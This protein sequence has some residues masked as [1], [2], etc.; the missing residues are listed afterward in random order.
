MREGLVVK[1]EKEELSPEGGTKKMHTGNIRRS[2]ALLQGGVH[3]FRLPNNINNVISLWEE[4]RPGRKIFVGS[5]Q[6]H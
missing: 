6:C 1:T 2:I 4:K 5:Q 3:L